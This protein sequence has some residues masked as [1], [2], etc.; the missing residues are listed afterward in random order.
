MRPVETDVDPPEGLEEFH[1]EQAELELVIENT[2]EIGATASVQLASVGTRSIALPVTFSLPMPDPGETAR[3]VTTIDETNSSIID[4]LESRPDRVAMSGSLV[5]STEGRVGTIRR[6]DAI[7]GSYTIRT[8][9]RAS[10]GEIHHRS[11]PFDFT[12]DADGQQRIRDDAVEMSMTGVVHNH[13]PVGLTA[14]IVFA[15]TVEELATAPAVE[16]E[17]PVIAAGTTAGSGK[18]EAEETTAF[19]ISLSRADFEFFARD[20]GWGQVVL[21]LN[22]PPGVFEVYAT[23]YV[24]V[25]AMMRARV[26]TS[27]DDE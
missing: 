19:E 22:G 18:V 3:V 8:P 9:L 7:S 17:L 27:S 20:Q 4:F 13:L 21:T 25:E 15:P 11:D 24:T 1:F 10:I 12:V 23:D 2:M 5:L 6:T 26:R 14:R 16:I